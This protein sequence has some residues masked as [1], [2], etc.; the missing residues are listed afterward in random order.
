MIAEF[1]KSMGELSVMMSGSISLFSADLIICLFEEMPAYDGLEILFIHEPG[2]H[3]SILLHLVDKDFFQNR[4][5]L[6]PEVLH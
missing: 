5:E 6:I 1:R 3:L 4:G 2:S